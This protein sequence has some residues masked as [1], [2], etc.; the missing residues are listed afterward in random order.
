MGDQNSL[1]TYQ[2][3]PPV[4]SLVLYKIRPARVIS[5]GEKIEIELDGGHSK[6]V[7]PKDIEMLHPGPLRHLSELIPQEGEPQAA[8]ELL[9]GSE[10]TLKDLAELAFDAF[11]PATAWAA[12]QWVSEGLSFS[13]T[14]SRIQARP[15]EAVERE[16]A[17][18]E[19]KAAEERDWQSFLE[20]M[21]A[22]TPAPEDRDRLGEVER[23]AVGLS[24]HSRILAALG[25]QPTPENA[26]R[27]LVQV[28]Y[29]QA[30]HNPYPARCGLPSRDPDLAVPELME[31]DRLDLTHL[32]AYAIDDEGNQDPDDAISID[33]DRLW[34][35][36]A[37]VA[38]LV[39]PESEAEREARTRGA[40]L[41]LPEGI[42]NMLPATVTDRLGLGLQP[43]SPALSFGLQCNEQGEILDVEVRRTWV[44]VER[45]SYESV[46]HRLDEGPFET[47]RAVVEPF[48][49]RRQADGAAGL[50]LPEVSVR[51]EA[52]RVRI[53]PIPRLASRAM[54]TEAMLMG[55]VAA[56]RFCHE[57]AIP[58]PYATQA[59]PEGIG[60]EPDLA[61]MYA[62]RRRF[63]PTRLSSTPDR[64]AGLG[65]TLYTRATSPLRRY[66]DLL[67]HQQI[68]AELTGRGGLSEDEVNARVA[69]AEVAAASVRRGE[70]LSNQHWKHVFLRENQDWRGDGVVVD[71]DE[72]RV[73]VLIPELAM[74]ARVRSRDL[75]GLNDRLRLGVTEVDVP[76][77][78]S[79]F[80]VVA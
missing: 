20:R 33:G 70:R 6:R 22:A 15:R 45:L 47:I 23:L 79:G 12:W 76:A 40:N 67:V 78:G 71:L 46:D 41:Y 44:R 62:R 51:V 21:A 7:R 27:A 18:R 38:A 63:K 42:V 56:A 14:P 55:G 29:W 65:L 3:S 25:H 30:N 68:R 26:H 72:R 75:P 50:D 54:V 35:H 19:T 58:I 37:D 10:T 28:G 61:S 34:I 59:L 17:E 48:R 39:D 69:E 64:H 31:E 36:V 43:I 13:G 24:E 8:W 5:A 60:D 73:T 77:L 2:S 74:E 9:E 66:S 32:P 80:R 11:T 49:A 1:S 16:R 53:R 4:N 52:G 57:R